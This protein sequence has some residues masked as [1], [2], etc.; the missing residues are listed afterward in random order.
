MDALIDR[1]IAIRR[2]GPGD[3]AFIQ[4][5]AREAFA[6][7]DPA[8]GARVLGLAERASKETLL[9][10]RGRERLGF[11]VLASQRETAWIEAIAVL[12]TERGRGVGTRLMQAAEHAAR[13]AGCRRLS[14]TTAQ[15]NV[16]ALELFLKRGFRIER[17]VP[18]YYTAGQDACVLTRALER[19]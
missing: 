13:R 4:R 7:F 16:E 19:G 6:V 14:L 11:L 5:L 3:D 15:A 18:R 8:A 2:R 1:A 10:E 9:A 17:R 12:S